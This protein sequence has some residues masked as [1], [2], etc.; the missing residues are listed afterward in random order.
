MNVEEQIFSEKN[1]VKNQM[2]EEEEIDE[3]NEEINKS[4]SN[5]RVES[6]INQRFEKY[7][8]NLSFYENI[9]NLLIEEKKILSISNEVTIYFIYYLLDYKKKYF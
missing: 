4:E 5:I 2:S 3:E 6:E 1:Y 9:S 7:Q 8:K